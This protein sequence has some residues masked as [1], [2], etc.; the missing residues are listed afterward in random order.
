MSLGS[1]GGLRVD[2]PLQEKQMRTT[3]SVRSADGTRIVFDVT[4][5]GSPLV[6]VGAAMQYRALESSQ[7]ELAEALAPR[8]TVYVYDRRGRG[9]SGD[10]PPYAVERELEDLEAVIGAA[11]GTAHVMGGSSG[12]VLSLRAAAHGLMIGRLALYEPPF[13]V[14]DS[15]PP[16]PSDEYVGRLDELIAAGRRRQAVE[17]FLTF[18]VRVPPEMLG[19]M[20][21]TPIW[22]AMES[23]AHTLAYDGRIM[24]ETMS[25]RTS[26]LEEFA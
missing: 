3:A 14:D 26:A 2:T 17:Y 25:G 12:A 22:P 24:G 4:G 20:R 5:H 11:G 1:G 16:V 21:R 13:I 19:E 8:F 18:A 23:V 9:E 15:R 6:L 10:T 7:S